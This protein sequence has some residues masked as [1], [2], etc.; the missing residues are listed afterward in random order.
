M[1]IHTKS[2]EEFSN[3]IANNKIVVVDFFATWCGP[4]KAISPLYA[5]L[6]ES[7]D[8]PFLK[9]DI[10]I[11]EEA[12]EDVSTLPSFCIYKDGVKHSGFSG[13]DNDKLTRLIKT[14]GNM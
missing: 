10:D 8:V 3:I 12:G 2:D 7:I 6:S 5:T 13:A 1:L 9:V 14:I 4:C 11:C